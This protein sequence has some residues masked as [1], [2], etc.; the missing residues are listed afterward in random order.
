MTTN[1]QRKNSK[2]YK[3]AKMLIMAT[4]NIENLQKVTGTHSHKN[5]NSHKNTQENPKI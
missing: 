2:T 3:T 1:G 5:K 4:K